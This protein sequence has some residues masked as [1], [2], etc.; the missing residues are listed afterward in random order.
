VDP[1]AVLGLPSTATLDEVRA[2]RRR[3][4][5]A[6]HPDKGGDPA[7]MQ[8]VNRAFDLAVKAILRPATSP[9]SAPPTSPPP[10]SPPTAASPTSRWTTRQR[11]SR[12]RRPGRRMEQ[13]SPSFSIELLPA[14]AFEALLVVVNWIGEVLV[15][16]PPYLLD[17]HLYEPAE[18]WCRIELLP[19][20][21]ASMVGL[22][23]IGPEGEDA[24]PV[25]DVRDV[26]VALLNSLGPP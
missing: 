15:D 23:V 26:L 16:D 14:E 24:P 18:C 21:G 9:A 2:A 4:A 17:A 10:T 8:E 20:A 7:R 6:L 5:K 1:F 22:T 3:L 25:D 12:G 13:D 19:E 11:P